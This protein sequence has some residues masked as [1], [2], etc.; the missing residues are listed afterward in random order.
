MNYEIPPPH[1]SG[2]N[3]PFS[4][5]D[6]LK[7]GTLAVASL[8]LPSQ[9]HKQVNFDRLSALATSDSILFSPAIE[10][11]SFPQQG[12]VLDTRITVYD[13]PSILGKKITS[14]W[15]DSIIP[16][17]GATVSTDEDSHNQIWYKVGAEG[18]AHSGAIQPVNTQ[19]NT[20][21]SNIPTG[22]IL[23]EVTVP[24]TDARWAAGK[25]QPVAY[26]YY[27]ETTH[28]VI[29]LSYD[30]AGDPWYSVLDDKWEYIFY[31]PASH[32]RLIPEAELHP[33]SPSIHPVFKRLEVRLN[34]QV[35]I[36]HE[37]EEPVF[38]ARISTG[39]K[40]SN[41][42]FSTPPGRYMTFHKRPSRHM[43]AGN[44][45]ANGYDLP[46]VPWNTYITESGIAFHGTYWHN[47]FGRPRSHGCI[48]LPTKAARWVYLWT[49]PVVPPEEQSAYKTSG[50]IVD[51][52]LS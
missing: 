27:Y 45:A 8:I 29:Q 35:L 24:Y 25:D 47:N 44:L 10:A 18:Y 3:K 6:F 20:P 48:N 41:G 50:T 23:A 38:M 31:V 52:V 21:D 9:R 43:A 46:G 22:G 39:A 28:W 49:I 13:Q 37:Y 1:L 7:L 51:I 26:R 5:R 40:F 11:Q 4:R 36:A 42:D 32:L 17:D 33:L 19:L 12:R 30:S 2:Y 16:I 34:Q 15:L 14:Y